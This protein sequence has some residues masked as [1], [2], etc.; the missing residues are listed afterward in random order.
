[1]TFNASN[2]QYKLV[3]VVGFQFDTFDTKIVKI[4]VLEIIHIRGTFVGAFSLCSLLTQHPHPN[5]K[6]THQLFI[7]S[8]IVRSFGPFG[9]QLIPQPLDVCELLIKPRFKPQQ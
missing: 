7:S 1:M 2:V 9:H 5:M 4:R 8:L 3:H 6:A